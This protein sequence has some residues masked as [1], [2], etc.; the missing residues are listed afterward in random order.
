MFRLNFLITMK[1][2]YPFTILM[3]TYIQGKYTAQALGIKYSMLLRFSVPK[4]E[5]TKA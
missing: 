2:K 4:F 1:E 5:P 3:K